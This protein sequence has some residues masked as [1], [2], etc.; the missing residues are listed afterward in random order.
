MR[1]PKCIYI[2]ILLELVSQ[3]WVSKLGVNIELDTEVKEEKLAVPV[4]FLQS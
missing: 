2:D 3:Q 4:G 1:K